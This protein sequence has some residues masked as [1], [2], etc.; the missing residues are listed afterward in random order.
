M[1]HEKFTYDKSFNNY[2]DLCKKE[3]AKREEFIL[4]AIIPKLK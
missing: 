2:I 3:T 4:S 1:Y